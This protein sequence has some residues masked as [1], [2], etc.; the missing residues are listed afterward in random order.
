MN[1]YPFLGN[2]KNMPQYPSKQTKCFAH[3]VHSRLDKLRYTNR[4]TI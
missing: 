2:F 3:K 1:T 4:P